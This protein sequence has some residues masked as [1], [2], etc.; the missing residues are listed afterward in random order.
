MKSKE[1]SDARIARRMHEHQRDR[2][3][4]GPTPGTTGDTQETLLDGSGEPLNAGRNS[5]RGSEETRR[6]DG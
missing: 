4:P 5:A 1:S 3:A 6:N 2:G